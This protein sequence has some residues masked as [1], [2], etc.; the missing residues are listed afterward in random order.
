MVLKLICSAG[1]WI[2]NFLNIVLIIGRLLQEA[3]DAT[4]WYFRVSSLALQMLNYE[5]GKLEAIY[6]SNIYYL[7]QISFIKSLI[8]SSTIPLKRTFVDKNILYCR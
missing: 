4:F 2:V 1:P 8:N 7:D 3:Y 5:N 6:Y